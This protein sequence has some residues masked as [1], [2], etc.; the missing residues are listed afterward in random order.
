LNLA[1]P[2]S[3]VNQTPIF[4]DGER[5]DRMEVAAA[6]G[7]ATEI[8]YITASGRRVKRAAQ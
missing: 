6:Y 7:G 4:I 8:T 1:R 5:V 3:A 2:K